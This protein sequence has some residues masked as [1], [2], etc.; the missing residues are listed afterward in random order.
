M[1]ILKVKQNSLITA[2]PILELT[3]RLEM[4]YTLFQTPSFYI[5]RTSLL[6]FGYTDI[7]LQANYSAQYEVISSPVCLNNHLRL[8]RQQ[9][10]LETCFCAQTDLA[11]DS[12]LGISYQ[13][14]LTRRSII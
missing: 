1:L 7:P 10:L 2:H 13:V 6:Y 5:Y 3:H 14:I 11:R 4:V 12:T 8:S 9:V